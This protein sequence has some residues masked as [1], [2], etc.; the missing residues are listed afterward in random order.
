MHSHE[1]TEAM[2]GGENFREFI[3]EKRCG[4]RKFDGSPAD[5]GTQ[6]VGELKLSQSS[7][8]KTTKR[9]TATP[10]SKSA[11]TFLLL[12]HYHLFVTFW[13]GDLCLHFTL[14]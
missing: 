13:S 5:E 6:S 3:V 2:C 10:K 14:C 4:K 9:R 7:N 12:T 8:Y 1:S 11:A